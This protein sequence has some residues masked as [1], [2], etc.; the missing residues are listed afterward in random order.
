MELSNKRNRG[1]L[2]KYLII[3]LQ[4]GIY[5]DECGAYWNARKE[6]SKNQTDGGMPKG[7]MCQMKELPM[8]KARIV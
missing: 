1:S 5:Q 8:A 7:H 6:H 3:G 2:E 4:E